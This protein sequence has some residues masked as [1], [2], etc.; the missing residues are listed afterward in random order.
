MVCCTFIFYSVLDSLSFFL[1]P[2]F[3]IQWRVVPFPWVYKLSVLSILSF[4]SWQSERMQS[5]VSIFFY[6]L[7]LSLCP[8]MSSTLEKGPQVAEK[9]VYSLYLSEISCSYLLFYLWHYNSRVSIWFLCRWLEYWQEWDI[10]VTRCH[11][12]RVNMWF[13]LKWYFLWTWVSLC[14]GHRC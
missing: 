2:F 13:K 1:D 3:F 11:C 6:L 9:E 14:L 8:S 4:N 12:V 10:E 5:V 7:R